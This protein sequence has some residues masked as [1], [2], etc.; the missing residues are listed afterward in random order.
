MFVSR[1]LSVVALTSITLFACKPKPESST[2]LTDSERNGMRVV[3]A[4]FDKAVLAADW[5]TVV[6]FYT[7]DGVL[8]PPNGPA[9]KGRPAMKKFFEGF[10][11]ITEF[12]ESVA[13]IEGEGHLAYGRGTYEMTMILPGAKAPFKDVGKTLAIWRK[14]PDGSWQ[15]S[16][17]SWN[18]DL[19][20]PR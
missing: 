18:S 8:L 15:V 1:T 14:Q 7:E 20:P 12:R 2:R 19:A 17:V 6:S 4:N 16:S 13:E 5:P 11:K 9:V 3:V 10:P